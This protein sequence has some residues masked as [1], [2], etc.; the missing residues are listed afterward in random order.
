MAATNAIRRTGGRAAFVVAD[1]ADTTQVDEIADIAI[2]EFG[3]LDTWVNNAGVSMCGRITDLS[4]EDMRRQMD[5][6]L[7]GQVYGSRTAV[8]DLRQS[9]GAL[10]SVGSALSDRAIPLQGGYCAAKHALK[11]FT[12]TVAAERRRARAKLGGS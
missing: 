1:V 7:W 2:R 3:R 8:R 4:I 11:A 10:I 6:N 12:D 5:V 9:G